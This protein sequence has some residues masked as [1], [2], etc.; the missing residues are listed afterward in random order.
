MRLRPI[1]TAK[2]PRIVPGDFAVEKVAANRARLGRAGVG[3][4]HRLAHDGD[5]VLA[6]PDHRHD[7]PGGDVLHQPAIE[8][9]L[10][11]GRVVGLG[12]FARHLHELQAEQLQTPPL[13]AG[14]DLPNQPA[15]HT[16]GLYQNKRLFHFACSTPM[17]VIYERLA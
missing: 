6:L 8:R 5:G 2:S 9:P 3:G 4:S 16:V 17:I 12:Q 14:D 13:Q 11:V 7:W 15:L 10:N 1:S